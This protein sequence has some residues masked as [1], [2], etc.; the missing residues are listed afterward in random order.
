MRAAATILAIIALAM[1]ALVG[2]ASRATPEPRPLDAPTAEFSAS[3]AIAALAPVAQAPRF[4]GTTEHARARDHLERGLRES[5]LDTSIVT[6]VGYVH[7]PGRT[8]ETTAASRVDSI[9]ATRA[10]TAPTGTLV[11]ATHYDTVAGSPGAADAGIGLATALEVARAVS[12]EPARRNDLVVLLTDGEEIGLA[13]AQAF[14]PTTPPVCGRRSSS[15][16][17]RP[18]AVPGGR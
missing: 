10:G 13:G 16:T 2:V 15:S 4:P 3:R 1:T 6:G 9:L 8:L 17:T 18:G 5:G 7:L 12:A 14:V 11:I